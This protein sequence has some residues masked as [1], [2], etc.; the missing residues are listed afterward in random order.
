MFTWYAAAPFLFVLPASSIHR[1]RRHK[2][3]LNP[4]FSIMLPTEEDEAAMSFDDFLRAHRVSSPVRTSDDGALLR[5]SISAAAVRLEARR[6]AR[7]EEQMARLREAATSRETKMRP[8]ASLLQPRGPTQPSQPPLGITTI[9]RELQSKRKFKLP[10]EVSHVRESTSRMV[11]ACEHSTNGLSAPSKVVVQ[12]DGPSQPPLVPPVQSCAHEVRMRVPTDAS[13][14][15]GAEVNSAPV[16][17]RQRPGSASSRASA[18]TLAQQLA[19]V[20]RGAAGRLAAERLSAD[21]QEAV[22]LRRAE[23]EQRVGLPSAND[24]EPAIPRSAVPLAN[25]CSQSYADWLDG[26]QRGWRARRAL[27]SRAAQSLRSQ[28]HDVRQMLADSPATEPMARALRAQ[29][30]RQVD[31]L[32][33]LCGRPV[34]RTVAPARKAQERNTANGSATQPSVGRSYAPRPHAARPRLRQRGLPVP[35]VPMERCLRRN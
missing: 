29:I 21:E 14:L 8:V 15:V 26:W 10:V 28:M 19:V 6:A 33:R 31:D 27:R 18:R 2:A 13:G 34:A 4:P 1:L 12:T 32:V 35:P 3:H 16:A 20:E 24:D 11:A 5:Q 17:S 23:E 25:A 7:K 9:E 22:R 30:R